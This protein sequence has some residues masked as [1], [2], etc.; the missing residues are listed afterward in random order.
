MASSSSRTGLLV[1]GTAIVCVFGSVACSS[2][3]GDAPS[4]RE[5]DP[6]GAGKRIR[7]VVNPSLKTQGDVDVTGAE[8]IYIDTFDETQDGKSRGTIYVQDVG[9]QAPYSGISLYSPSFIPSSLRVSPGDVLDLRGPYVEMQ[10]IGTAHFPTGHKLPQLSTPIGTFR[11]ETPP[12]APVEINATDLN[13]Y[14]T[15]RKWLNMLVTIKNVTVSDT[16]FPSGKRLSV[17]ITSNTTRDAVTITNEFYDVQAADIAKDTKFASV[18][19]IVT[20]FFNYHVVPRSPADLELA[21]P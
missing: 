15:G 16:P 19:G 17:H 11:Y 18:T 5:P 7:E 12:P 1:L 13:D 6:L 20:W 10:D 9:S 21:A 4:H 8:V 3:D 14:D 2:E